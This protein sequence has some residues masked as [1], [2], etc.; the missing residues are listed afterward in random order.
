VLKEEVK[1]ERGEEEE[2]IRREKEEAERLEKER[3]KREKE[4]AE[5]LEK[6]RRDEEERIEQERKEAERLEK[7]RR[8]EEERIEQEKKEA[9]RL[10]RSASSRASKSARGCWANPRS[11]TLCA[12]PSGEAWHVFRD[13]AQRGS[14]ARF[15]CA[16]KLYRS[17]GK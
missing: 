12:M 4:E 9:E 17:L 16:A 7:E 6:E 1:Q 8:E 13:H 11:V 5:R 10:K 3:I 14:M 15:P 2:R